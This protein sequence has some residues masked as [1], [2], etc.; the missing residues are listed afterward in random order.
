MQKSDLMQDLL[1]VR[2]SLQQLHMQDWPSCRQAVR[3]Y[4]PCLSL[5]EEPITYHTVNKTICFSEKYLKNTMRSSRMERFQNSRRPLQE[6]SE[7]AKKMPS[8]TLMPFWKRFCRCSLSEPTDLRKTT[9]RNS[10]IPFW[11]ISRDWL[12]T[13]TFH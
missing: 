4:M 9:S 11:P 12:Q 3:Q 10:R 8:Q 7:E 6:S 13:P 2:N 5:W 1:M